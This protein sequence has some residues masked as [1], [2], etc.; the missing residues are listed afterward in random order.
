[1][2]FAAF[3]VGALRQVVGAGGVLV[4]AVAARPVTVVT[5]I[6]IVGAADAVLVSRPGVA[7][8]GVAAPRVAAA[9]VAARGVAGALPVG[10]T[11]L[12]ALRGEVLARRPVLVFFAPVAIGGVVVVVVFIVTS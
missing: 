9:R 7:A 2:A 1:A 5:V 8:A 4:A 12:G 3:L 6:V 11:A 10:P